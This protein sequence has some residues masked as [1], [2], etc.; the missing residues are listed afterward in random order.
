MGTQ[1]TAALDSDTKPNYTVATVVAASVAIVNGEFAAWV[2]N[3]VGSQVEAINGLVK[4]SQALRE[5]GWPNPT[6][7]VF[8]SAVYNTV[9]HTMTVALAAV[10]PTLAETDVCVLQGLDFTQA[11]DS[12]S[13]HV[14][15]MAESIIEGALKAA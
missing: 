9:T 2:G 14:R 1:V 12:N 15:R 5:A 8:N 7:G 6:T 13:G 3:A 4:C 11:G 10:L